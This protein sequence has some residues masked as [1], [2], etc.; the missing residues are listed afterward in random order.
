MNFLNFEESIMK[1]LL[2]LVHVQQSIKMS[3]IEKIKLFDNAK[4]NANLIF[5]NI[6]SYLSNK[7][8]YNSSEKEEILAKAINNIKNNI[9]KDI[10]SGKNIIINNVDF[11][12]YK[13]IDTLTDIK[14]DINLTKNDI[15][16]L[17]Y[18]NELT[19]DIEKE[20]NDKKRLEDSRQKN[21]NE[22]NEIKRK[23]FLTMLRGN[24]NVNPH[25]FFDVN[26]Y[27][28]A[29][30][31]PESINYIHDR[32]TQIKEGLNFIETQGERII[33]M[34]QDGR[35]IEYSI[36]VIDANNDFIIYIQ[37]FIKVNESQEEFYINE[38]YLNNQFVNVLNAYNL[39]KIIEL[40]NEFGKNENEENSKKSND[41][42]DFLSGK[43]I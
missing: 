43:I 9:E 17:L 33:I 41:I 5:S 11:S 7:N 2:F 20:T 8:E 15:K 38:Q 39:R 42:D 21:E 1:Y 26:N 24:K 30:Y 35:R 16:Q 6:Q 32:T 12:F 18:Y 40:F 10:S 29:N 31:T 27:I 36:R 25:R 34:S 4:E 37:G 22:F 23:A 13:I 14:Y 19:R 28:L 3:M